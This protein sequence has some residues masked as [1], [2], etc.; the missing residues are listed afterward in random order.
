MKKQSSHKKIL[1]RGTPACRGKTEGVIKVVSGDI[2]DDAALMKALLKVQ[3]GN[4]LVTE[5]TRPLFVVAMR[6]ASAIITD[7]G[8]ILCHAAMVSREFGLPCIVGT[9]KAT[10]VLK[11]G[12]K[13]FV[14]AERGVIYER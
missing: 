10:K 5:M 4:V 1:L 13:V 7:R 11:N 2:W 9:R 8:G 14:D 3:K 12:Q 6:R